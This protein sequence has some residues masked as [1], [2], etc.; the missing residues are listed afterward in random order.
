MDLAEA[1]NKLSVEWLAE[2]QSAQD[3]AVDAVHTLIADKV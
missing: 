3:S 2:T 1:K